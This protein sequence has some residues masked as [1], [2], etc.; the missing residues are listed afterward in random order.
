MY[1]IAEKVLKYA[2]SKAKYVEAELSYS[3]SLQLLGEKEEIKSI[4]EDLKDKLSI[5]VTLKKASGYAESTDLKNYKKVVN[6]AVKIAKTSDPDKEFKDIPGPQKLQ[7]PKGIFDQRVKE[8][9]PQ[10]G[11]R[12]LNDLISGSKVKRRINPITTALSAAYGNSYFVNSNGVEVTEKGTSING[13]IEVKVGQVSASEFDSSRLLDFSFRKIGRK[14]GNLALK[15]LNPSKIK[16][17]KYPT[18]FDPRAAS[19][20]FEMLVFHLSADKVQRNMSNFQELTNQRIGVK[21]LTLVDN[22]L[23]EGGLSTS[24]TDAEG[25]P[26]QKTILVEEG[27]LK[28]FLYDL[29]TALKE[30][31]ESTGNCNSLQSRPSIGA[32]NLIVK[33]GKNNRDNLIQSLDKGILVTDL[34]GAGYNVVSGDF[35]L[36][37]ENGFLI[38]KG[39]LKPIKGAMVA[40]NVFNLIKNIKK[41]CDNPRQ[42]G[43][44][45]VPTL[46]IKELQVV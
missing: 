38:R 32:S 31:R 20:L 9:T 10:K 26:R 45:S 35:S 7:K 22:G 18:M 42:I 1:R 44:V 37:V 46:L 5:R 16:P 40:G 25:Y 13:E 43:K 21:S 4:Q 30:K 3:R 29:Y 11:I 17:G 33:P 6:K 8:I 39:E 27:I 23:L 34:S 41:I 28:G 14:A 24:V 2:E 36:Q 12:L 15:S 19:S